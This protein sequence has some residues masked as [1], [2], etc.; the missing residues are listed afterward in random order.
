[1]FGS[2]YPSI[3]AKEDGTLT[4]MAQWTASWNAL[5]HE[6]KKV[7]QERV[8]AVRLPLL[9]TKNYVLISIIGAFR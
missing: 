4:E 5:N 8:I 3:P 2:E 9:S 7:Y 1:L 6:E